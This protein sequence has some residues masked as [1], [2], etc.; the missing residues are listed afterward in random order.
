MAWRLS[1]DIA[2]AHDC[3][4]SLTP[5]SENASQSG[6]RLSVPV[7]DAPLVALFLASLTDD[8]SY[9]DA[10]NLTSELLI[11][12]SESAKPVFD[13][14][15]TLTVFRLIRILRRLRELQRKSA[16]SI[17]PANEG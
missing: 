13:D 4:N 1:W 6:Y 12:S 8:T 7:D 16:A 9:Q 5:A 11:G 3:G 15:Q 2:S 17:V 10:A 14:E